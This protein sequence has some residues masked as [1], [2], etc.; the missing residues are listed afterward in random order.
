MKSR[1]PEELRLPTQ[2]TDNLISLSWTPFL[3]HKCLSQE[4]NNFSWLVQ[5]PLPL[6]QLWYKI[7]THAWHQFV[8][9]VALTCVTHQ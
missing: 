9:E 7:L 3:P 2:V 6:P 4:K 1:T 8:L 5:E